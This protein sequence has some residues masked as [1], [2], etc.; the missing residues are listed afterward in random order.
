ML[1]LESRRTR[2]LILR[3][4]SGAA[5][6]AALQQA[7]DMAEAR[8]AWVTGFGALESAEI[9]IAGHAPTRTGPGAARRVDA[10]CE[11]LSLTGNVA[12]QD[13]AGSLRLTVTLARETELGLE[14]FGGQ[15]VSARCS[16][17]EL[18]VVVFDDVTLARAPDDRARQAVTPP[19]SSA[20]ADATRPAGAGSGG[21]P[22]APMAML[23]D[24]AAAAPPVPLRTKPREEPE[25]YPEPGDLVNH[26]HFGEC[27]IIESDG[28]RIRLR[29]EKDGRVRDV[30]LTMLRIEPPTVDQT[31]GK[32]H[33]QLAR[34]N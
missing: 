16:A 11:L 34:K 9:V 31:T 12:L 19:S 5:L 18:H 24:P 21:G 17:V 20:A 14:V 22:S 8:A 28:D 33:F 6:P 10:P 4:D 7:L 3:L 32:R 25:A 2:S 27:T 26:F 15:L 13:G 29:Q 1:V 30:S 23:R